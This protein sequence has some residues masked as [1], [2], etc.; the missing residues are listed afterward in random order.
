[1]SHSPSAYVMGYDDRERRRLAIQASI[2]HPFTEQLLGRAGIAPG[3]SVLDLGCGVGDVS[4][5]A[6]RLVGRSGQVT[7]IDRD[8]TALAT[9]KHRAQQ[10]SLDNI[11]FVRADCHSYPS[12]P[13]FDAVLGRHI[14]I[15]TAAPLSLM[16]TS[17][18]LLRPGG[19]AI[20]HEYDFSVVHRAYP[21][22][23]L[24]DQIMRLFWEFWCKAGLPGNIG[25]QLFHLFLEAGFSAPDCRAE[26]P[27]DGGSDSPFYEWIAESA[28][29]ILPRAR[30]LGIACHFIGD[31]DTLV[32][33]LR[34]E[35]VARQACFPAPVLVGGFARKP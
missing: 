4:I 30:T 17:L 6:A 23:P 10:E 12:K 9:A 25:T 2:L 31:I 26:Y 18:S 15:H 16:Q 5:I 33:R 3:M 11:V 34:D 24:R 32:Q 8:E 28:M 19:V 1:M 20:F 13:S 21:E 7:A 22:L 29:S 27:I 14:L 35:S